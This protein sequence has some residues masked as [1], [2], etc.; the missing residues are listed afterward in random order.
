MGVLPAPKNL[1]RKLRTRDFTQKFYSLKSKDI[2]IRFPGRA[3]KKSQDFCINSVFLEFNNTRGI[4][5][6][7]PPPHDLKTHEC[8]YSNIVQQR[9]V[10]EKGLQFLNQGLEVG[11]CN[12]FMAESLPWDHTHKMTAH[13]SK[14]FILNMIPYTNAQNNNDK[15]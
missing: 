13:S 1:P 7:V 15:V 2:T 5:L 9:I 8:W 10:M 11:N 4:Q 14:S 3:N 6:S 12:K